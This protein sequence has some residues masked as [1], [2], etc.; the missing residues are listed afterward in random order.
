MGMGANLDFAAYTEGEGET[1][2][3]NEAAAEET[4]T[5][6]TTEGFRFI[7]EGNEKCT[8]QTAEERIKEIE[9]T[10]GTVLTIGELKKILNDY[11]KYLSDDTKIIIGTGSSQYSYASRWFGLS[12]NENK[13]SDIFSLVIGEKYEIPGKKEDK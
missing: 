6:K 8:A 9:S 5:N 2:T 11:D 3:V 13:P 7:L 4:T 1:T 12:V 10:V